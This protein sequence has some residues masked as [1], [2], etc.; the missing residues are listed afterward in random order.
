VLFFDTIEVVFVIWGA[1]LC[2][3]I[4][5]IRIIEIDIVNTYI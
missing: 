1:E 2:I 3:R 4:W 5:L